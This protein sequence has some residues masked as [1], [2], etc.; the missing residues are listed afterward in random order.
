MNFEVWDRDNRWD[1]DLLGKGSVLP[2]QGTNVQTRMKLKHGTLLVSITANCGP[3]LSG[4][5]CEKYAPSP[6]SVSTLTD[7]NPFKPVAFQES[8]GFL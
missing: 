6:D 1:D 3:S 7:Y 5:Y 2:S 8:N 4:S